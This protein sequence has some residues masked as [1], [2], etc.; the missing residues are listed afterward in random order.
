MDRGRD[1]QSEGWKAECAFQTAQTVRT[2]RSAR[3]GLR[4]LGSRL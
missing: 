2:A 1:G 4:G 3:D